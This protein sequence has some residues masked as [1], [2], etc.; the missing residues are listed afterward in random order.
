MLCFFLAVVFLTKMSDERLD[1]EIS[2][3]SGW[4]WSV[5]SWKNT[6]LSTDN[7][8]L[9]CCFPLHPHNFIHSRIEEIEKCSKE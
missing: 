2:F 3:N 4:D 7:P 5:H 1:V 6:C 9:F 8:W